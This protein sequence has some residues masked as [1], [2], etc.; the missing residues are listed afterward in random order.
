M[1]FHLIKGDTP[2]KRSFQYT[3]KTKIMQSRDKNSGIISSK[4]T[5]I[6]IRK[7][8]ILRIDVE[9]KNS[10][11]LILFRRYEIHIFVRWQRSYFTFSFKFFSRFETIKKQLLGKLNDSTVICQQITK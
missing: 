6:S 1:F 5:P 2:I 4:N 3:S 9:V 7:I 8:L 10:L 11:N